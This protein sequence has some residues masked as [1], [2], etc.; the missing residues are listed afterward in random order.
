MERKKKQ[1]FRSENIVQKT[2]KGV[3]G[4][5]NKVTDAALFDF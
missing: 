2:K 1:A 3:N 5:Q 4:E